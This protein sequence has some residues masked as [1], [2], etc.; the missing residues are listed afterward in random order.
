MF[1]LLGVY[2]Y[3]STYTYKIKASFRVI[4]VGYSLANEC[5]NSIYP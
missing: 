3:H 1:L 4:D 2:I 5:C